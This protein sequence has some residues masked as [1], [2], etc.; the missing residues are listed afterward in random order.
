MTRLR[1]LTLATVATIVTGLAACQPTQRSA[2]VSGAELNGKAVDQGLAQLGAT[3]F[4]SK[5]CDMCHAF[6]KLRAAPD[7]AGIMERR[8][9]A[10]TKKWLQETNMMIETDP[11][12][13]DMV[14]QWKGYKMPE[15]KL[16][17]REVDGLF[18]FFAQES[19]R[20]RGAG[21]E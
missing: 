8:D 15:I 3:V 1:I 4:R 5:G 20:V 18:H 11:Q 17:D 21:G 7:L 12:A 14:K 6:G 9:P 13:Q 19:A 2:A 10:W 16:S